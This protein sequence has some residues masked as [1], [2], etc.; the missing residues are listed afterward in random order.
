MY[1]KGDK[2]EDFID[3]CIDIGCIIVWSISLLI[4]LHSFIF[5]YFPKESGYLYSQDI[6]NA[7]RDYQEYPLIALNKSQ[8]IEEEPKKA[9]VVI[10][11]IE[12]TTEE[13]EEFQYPTERYDYFEP[14]IPEK[15]IEKI[16]VS[17]TAYCCCESCCEK[18]PDHPA[19][20]LTFSGLNLMKA[21]SPHI[22][23][24]DL[25][26]FPL[27]TKVY[28]ST[29]EFFGEVDGDYGYA[30]VED[31]G[32]KIQDLRIDLYF[33]THE[34]A[35]EWAMRDVDLYVIEYPKGYVKEN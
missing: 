11:V 13:V 18:L 5:H 3:K 10:E 17:S 15:Y 19:F 26:Y 7:V 27:G 2:R 24:A 34:Q 33:P 30:T 22:I 4:W 32:G 23:A 1:T 35:V 6:K 12:K 9:E 31:I 16:T 8:Y 28:I 25:D 20:G 29:L 14:I 21:K